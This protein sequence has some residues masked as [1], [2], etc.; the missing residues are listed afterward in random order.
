MEKK[1]L[2][3]L[4][5]APDAFVVIDREG[6]IFFVNVQTE[7]LF[8]YGRNE[9]IGQPME[10]LLPERLRKLHIGHRA[11]FILDPKTRP[12]G[13]GLDLVGCRKDGSEFPVEISLS[14]IETDDG[15]LVTSVIRD[16]TER[17]W[18]EDEIL[19]LN[20]ELEQRVIV[21][22]RALGILGVQVSATPTLVEFSV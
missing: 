10:M 2:K 9:L 15:I 21:L 8:G 5:F 17:K 1:S 20:R 22:A 4:E 12:M 19:R 6:K 7:K 3:F 18:A 16:I 13:A 11:G 14:P